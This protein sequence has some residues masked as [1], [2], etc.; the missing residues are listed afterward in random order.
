MQLTI[1]LE[2]LHEFH[3]I[4]VNRLINNFVVILFVAD[5]QSEDDHYLSLLL[6][7]DG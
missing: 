7:G 1:L 2:N 5:F 6:T 3:I 4:L